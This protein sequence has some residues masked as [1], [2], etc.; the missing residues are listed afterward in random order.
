MNSLT[1]GK[2]LKDGQTGE[3]VADE[4]LFWHWE[5][6]SNARSADEVTKR[7]HAAAVKKMQVSGA[8]AGAGSGAGSLRIIPHLHLLPLSRGIRFLD[9]SYV[10]LRAICMCANVDRPLTF[11]FFPRS[12]SPSPSPL[13]V[14]TMHRPPDPAQHEQEESLQPA[15]G[16]DGR[17]RGR[18]RSPLDEG[19]VVLHGRR[20]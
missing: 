9:S 10:A 19:S 8:G 2:K 14:P 12:P 6:K 20:H 17:R 3:W 13:H 16:Q 1:S 15:L 4:Q 5:S 18:H 7:I 11:D